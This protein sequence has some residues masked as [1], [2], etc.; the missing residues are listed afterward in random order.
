[1]FH[2]A[3]SS[4]HNRAAIDTPGKGSMPPVSEASGTS[5]S[6][7]QNLGTRGVIGYNRSFGIEEDGGTPR[8]IFED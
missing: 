8:R 4:V 2:N 5:G 3:G 7:C 6:S 1:M